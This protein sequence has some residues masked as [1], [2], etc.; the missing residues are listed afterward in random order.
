MG[1]RR[2]I[3]AARVAQMIVLREEGLTEREIA[4]RLNFSRSSVH[5]CIA[6]YE[7]TGE[8]VARKRGQRPRV[9][10]VS[11]D[12]MIRDLVKK[13]PAIS[14]KDILSNLPPDT[15]ISPRTIRRR[16]LKDFHLRSY[17]A[18]KKPLLSE[19][20]KRD[21]LAFCNRYKNWTKEDWHKVMFSDESTVSQFQNNFTRVRRP[22]GERYNPQYTKACMKHPK[23]VMF[24]GA[25]SAH[26][27]GP[28]WIMPP[29][30]TINAKVYLSILKQ[31][32]PTWMPLHECTIFQHDGAPCHRANGVKR[33]MASE[34]II[35]LD[36][37]PGS[38]PDLNPIEHC[39]A[40]V[41]KKVS[42]LRP[43][44]EQDII[45]K[46]KRV[47]TQEITD[48]Y[49]RTLV[50]SIPDRIQSVLNANGGSTKY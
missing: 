32:L 27:R 16:L 45:H 38:S 2:D 3:P 15:A 21:R 39:W 1:K 49:C 20:N 42:D 37:W 12:S 24:W 50:E 4:H 10:G 30:T 7:E 14:S 26:G 11:T 18:A 40:I 6:R 43:T 17:R 35:P 25:I 22:S 5:K 9:S 31:K 48:E 28:L 23:T 44:G 33:W 29:K 13:D 46:L 19:K 34:N 8:F 47:W 36:S 41:K